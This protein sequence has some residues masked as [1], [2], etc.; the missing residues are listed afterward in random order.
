MFTSLIFDLDDTL[1]NQ[2]SLL[3][4]WIINIFDNAKADEL[5]QQYIQC[6]PQ[7]TRTLFRQLALLHDFSYPMLREQYR[8]FVWNNIRADQKLHTLLKNLRTDYKMAIISNGGQR[9]QQKKI[10]KAGLS[11]YFQVITISGVIGL[12][13]PQPEIFIQTLKKLGSQP[14]ES[15]FIGDSL[16]NDIEGA[17]NIGMQTCWLNQQSRPKESQITPSY[18][19]DQISKLESILS[20]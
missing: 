12:R 15:L 20:L 14:N 8:D 18:H 16:V 2:Q 4:A 7:N 9:N 11:P 17:S 19:I 3:Q 6:D 1:I 5:Y 10:Q 13:K